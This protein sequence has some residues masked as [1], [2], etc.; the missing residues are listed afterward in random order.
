MPDTLHV[1]G[2][3]VPTFAVVTSALMAVSRYVLKTI[4]GIEEKLSGS[5]TQLAAVEQQGHLLRE[6]L[7]GKQAL[8][9]RG[10]IRKP[11]VLALQ[12]QA[13]NLQGEGGR[14][15]GDI[16]D[17]RERVARAVEQIEGIKKNAMKIAADQLQEVSADLNDVR[18][19]IHTVRGIL[20]R[21]T[22]LAPVRGTVVKLRYHTS[23][24]VI[25]AGK[26]IMEIVSLQEELIIE[27]RVRPQ[28]ID[29]IKHSQTAAIRL[30]ALNQRTTP[31]AT[32]RVIYI[33]ADALPDEKQRAYPG[34][35]DLYVVRV[36]LDPASIEKILDFQP[37]PGMPAEVYIQTTER[38]FFE[39]L[40][41]PIRDSMAR[42]FR[43]S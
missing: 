25:E 26:N 23:G 17:A 29:K 19:R 8:L 6:E 28:D 39:Y 1:G 42:A 38:T 12:R 2:V 36:K 37:T 32:G 31:M 5:R 9:H 43:E 40:M 3:G 24:G 35:S 14:I 41:Q 33:S 21:S 18:E 16:G 10:Y 34:L 13:A 20:D 15:T 4:D 7:Q 22:I 27:A 11:E 30:T